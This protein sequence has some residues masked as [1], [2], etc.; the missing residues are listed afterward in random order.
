MTPSD[1][2]ARK[3][4]P[5]VKEDR[6]RDQAEEQGEQVE[7]VEEAADVFMIGIQRHPSHEVAEG[8]P[9]SSAGTKEPTMMQRSQRRRQASSLRLPR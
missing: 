5:W 9:Q 4:A 3:I 8:T 1:F 6:A 7:Q 2:R